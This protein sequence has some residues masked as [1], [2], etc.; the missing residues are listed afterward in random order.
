M[1]PGSMRVDRQV[2]ACPPEHHRLAG[3]DQPIHNEDRSVWIVYNGEVFNYP[4]LRRRVRAA[5]HQLLHDHRHRS[6]VHL[7]EE[8]GPDVRK[9]QRPVCLCH[10]GRPQTLPASGPRPRGDPPPVLSPSAGT[11][12]AVCLRNQ[13]A[14]CRPRI[15]RSW[16]PRPF[17]TFSPA[18]PR[19][20]TEPHL[21]A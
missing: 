12:A 6:L 3:G 17:P 5:G 19:W 11:T 15:H 8:M 14:L 7:Y 21:P 2:W 20:T 16:M 18:G 9:A 13:S 1:R 10:L 4:E